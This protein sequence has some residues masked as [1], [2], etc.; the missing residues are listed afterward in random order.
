MFRLAKSV[1]QAIR[2][3]IKQSFDDWLSV[4]LIQ[5][6]YRGYLGRKRYYKLWQEWQLMLRKRAAVCVQRQFRGYRGRLL[7]AVSRFAIT[8]TCDVNHLFLN[9]ISWFVCLFVCL[10]L[11]VCCA[12]R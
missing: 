8:L 3:R 10:E 1:A 11:F 12:A 9:F 6:A 5:R 4:L 7:A 2:E